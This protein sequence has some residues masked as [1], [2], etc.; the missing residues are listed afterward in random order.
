M[1]ARAHGLER[2]PLG[3]AIAPP[4]CVYAHLHT[5]LASDQRGSPPG[6]F[7]HPACSWTGREF[8]RSLTSRAPCPAMSRGGEP[9]YLAHA[10]YATRERAF[11]QQIG[12]YRLEDAGAAAVVMY[13]L[14]E[15][16]I[17]HE[18]QEFDD[19]LEHLHRVKRA[20]DIP[21]IGSLNG[22]SSGGWVQYAQRIEQAG[23]DAV[24]LNIYYLP[25]DPNLSGAELEEEYVKLVRDVRATVKI[26]IA[27]KLSPFFTSLPHIARRFVEAGGH[28]PV[29]VNRVFQPDF[30]LEEL[31]V[32][33]NLELS[34]SRG[35]L[36]P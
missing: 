11:C 22:I 17:T 25:A 10:F 35:S 32:I 28:G 18:S 30:D 3:P 33:P 36:F 23:A 19:Y 14:F 6:C 20:V 29:V 13:S 9:L 21:V 12:E 1:S 2:A 31:E 4:L 15:E 24:E 16:Q 27:L 34:T 7:S 8:I 26:P 5:G